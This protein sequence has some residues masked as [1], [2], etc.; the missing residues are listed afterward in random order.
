MLVK[1]LGMRELSE[2]NLFAETFGNVLMRALGVGTAEPGLVQVTEEFLALE[3]RILHDREDLPRPGIAAGC[4]YL[5]GGLVSVSAFTALTDEQLR[6]ATRLYAADLLLGNPDRQA[7]NPNCAL[8]G[9]EVLAYD[10]ELCFG[11]LLEPIGERARP[12]EVS[13]LPLASRHVFHYELHT[14]RKRVDFEPFLA[15]LAALTDERLAELARGLPMKWR[16]LWVPS[17]C[18]RIGQAR[19]H[20]DELR[21][22]LARGI[23]S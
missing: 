23:A 19:E 12:W 7:S 6:E 13:K 15:A 11:F 1:A 21:L 2:R 22:E 20:P 8:R 4:E 3:Q 9:H 10:F 16:S 5:R 14:R 17:V 18:D